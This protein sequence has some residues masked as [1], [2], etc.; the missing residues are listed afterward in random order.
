VLV[1]R[2][3]DQVVGSLKENLE[4]LEKTGSNYNSAMKQK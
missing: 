3:L 4:L 2:E 1:E